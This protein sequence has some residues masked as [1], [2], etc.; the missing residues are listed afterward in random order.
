MKR[1][2]ERLVERVVLLE[3]PPLPEPRHEDQVPRRRDREELGRALDDAEHER[4]P[5]RE[6]AG[7]VPHPEDRQDGGENDQPSRERRGAAGAHRVI[8]D[9]DVRSTH[10]ELNSSHFADLP[11]AQ[12]LPTSPFPR[13]F[14]RAPSTGRE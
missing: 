3:I 14:P 5:V 10:P 7:C 9:A 12:P 1:H 13:R 2:V 6:R 8:L 4:L 11:A